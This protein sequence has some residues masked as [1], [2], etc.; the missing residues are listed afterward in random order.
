MPFGLSSASEEYQ[1]RMNDALCDMEGVK[2]FVDDILIYDQG[3]TM[4]NAI[5]DHDRKVHS[6]FKRLNEQNIK[7]NKDK[8]QFKLTKLTYMGHVITNKGV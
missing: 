6:L 8:I 5:K 2:I 1:R 4:E 3:V 7:L